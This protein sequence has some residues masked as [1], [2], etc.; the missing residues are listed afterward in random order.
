MMCTPKR[1]VC[2]ACPAARI[3]QG[4]HAPETYPQKK[5]KKA[6]PTRQVQIVVL[7]DVRGRLAL[8]ARDAALLG[9]LYGFE[10]LPPEAAL[11]KG[12]RAIG[13]VRHAYSHF[14]LEGSVYLAVA[15]K[16]HNR[17]YS[18]TEIDTMPLS[19]LDHKVLALVSHQLATK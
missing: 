17:L 4:K 13:T 10:Q 6:V 8:A 11:P 16:G 7:R 19:G 14:K 18:L 15:P 9:G 1:P 5:A 2:G 3:C 12:A